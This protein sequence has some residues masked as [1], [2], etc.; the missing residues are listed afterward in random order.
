MAVGAR[1]RLLG[2]DCSASDSLLFPRKLGFETY[3]EESS[4]PLL[5]STAAAFPAGTSGRV[6]LQSPFLHQKLPPTLPALNK[7]LKFTSS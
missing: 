3:S 4:M 5:S 2:T 6:E 7:K 1:L